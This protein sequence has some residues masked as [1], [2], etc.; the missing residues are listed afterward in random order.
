MN[1]H[2]ASSSAFSQGNIEVDVIIVGAGF[3]GC[4]ALH[5]MRQQG[6]SAKILE[7]GSDFGGVWHFNSYPGARVDSETPMYQLDLPEIWRDFNFRSKYPGHDE[8]KAYFKHM[9]TTL[10]LQKDTIFKTRINEATYDGNT[11]QWLLHTDSGLTAKAKYVVFAMGCN[12]KAY[13]PNFRGVHDFAGQKVHPAAWPGNLQVSGKKVAIIG[14][15]ATGIQIVQELAKRD[16]ELT[17]FVRNPGVAVRMNQKEITEDEAQSMKGIYQ[18]LFERAKYTHPSGYANNVE[19]RRF[20]DVDPKQRQEHYERLWSM[21]GFSIFTGNFPDFS[22]D[23]TANAELYQFWA[24]KVRERMT[25]PVKK[26]MMAPLEQKAWIAAKRPSLE[27]DYFEMLDRPNVRIV[28]VKKTPIKSFVPGGMI[29]ESV[30][31]DEEEQLDFDI[32]IFATGYDS[33]TGSLFDANIRDKNG[34]TLQ[35]RWANGIR[36]YLGTMVPDMPN[37]FLLYG[38]QSPSSLANGPPFL[39]LQVDWVA[40]LMAKAREE[41]IEALEPSAE[42]AEGWASATMQAYQ[43]LLH[44]ETDSWWNGSNIPGKKKEPLM[45]LGGLQAWRRCCE[46]ALKDWSKFVV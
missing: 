19:M 36:T 42:A 37:A 46:D 11:K 15:G 8:L 9:A 3:G 34:V 38:P 4:Y 28:D 41:G 33:A 14:Q 24:K 35:Q 21:G 13:I 2:V 7:A 39:Q 43:S 1:G 30:A 23:K 44:R 27:M 26:D 12:N 16:C 20:A 18:A 40:K 17:V 5:V 22:F 25:D 45:W 29:L 32:V 10:D 6:Y 31:T